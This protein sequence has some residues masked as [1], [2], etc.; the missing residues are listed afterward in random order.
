MV[1]SFLK[2]AAESQQAEIVLGKL[3]IQKA[4]NAR[5]KEFGSHMIEAHKMLSQELEQLAYKAGVELS[6]KLNDEH[7]QQVD[8]LSKLSGHPFDRAYL[9][10]VLVDHE[11]DVIEFEQ[12]AQVLKDQDVGPWVFAT[13]PTLKEHR[14]KARQVN[15]SLQTN[16]G[17]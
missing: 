5:V 1:E 15:Y 8:E 7:R 13:L 4:V 10:Y 14:Q 9:Q 16:V 6:S 2:K 12:Q 17:M 11:Q 3:A